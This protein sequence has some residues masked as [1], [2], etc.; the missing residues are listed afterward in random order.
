MVSIHWLWQDKTRFWDPD[1]LCSH[2]IENNDKPWCSLITNL[3][4]CIS[5]YSGVLIGSWA[6]GQSYFCRRQHHAVETSGDS[7]LWRGGRKKSMFISVLYYLKI[8]LL[9]ATHSG[10]FFHKLYLTHYLQRVAHNSQAQITLW[11]YHI[12]RSMT[13]Q[14]LMPWVRL[15]ST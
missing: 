14:F 3:V 12:L 10:E 5:R 9:L 15:R 8:T 11:P 7:S 4:N 1:C 13:W 2:R 6:P